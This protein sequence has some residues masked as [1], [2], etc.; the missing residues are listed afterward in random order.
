M[1]ITRIFPKS[2]CE[3]YILTKNYL[4]YYVFPTPRAFHKRSFQSPVNI[5]TVNLHVMVLI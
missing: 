2:T 1:E 3:T 4:P 5:P